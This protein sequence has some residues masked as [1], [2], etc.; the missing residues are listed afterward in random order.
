MF[1]F[2]IL[3]NINTLESI[4]FFKTT[5]ENSYQVYQINLDYLF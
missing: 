3:F 5:N 4:K 1:I 2:N